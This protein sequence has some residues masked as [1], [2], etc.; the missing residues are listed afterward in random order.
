MHAP[1]PPHLPFMGP[2]FK[3]TADLVFRYEMRRPPPVAESKN[4]DEGNGTWL[5]QTDRK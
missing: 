2:T 5:S 3:T 1:C 4:G